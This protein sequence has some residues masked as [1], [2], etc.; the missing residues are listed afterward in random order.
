MFI[1]FIF[2]ISI[3]LLLHKDKYNFNFSL[4]EKL[5]VLVI[6]VFSAFRYGIGWD[7]FTYLAVIQGNL[8]T[9]I[10]FNNEF[11]NRFI[12]DLARLSDLPQLYFIFNSAVT[13]LLVSVTIK[14]NSLHFGLSL[15]LFIFFPFF[16]LNSFSVVRNFT[17]IA[18]VFYASKYIFN[19]NFI[20]YLLFIFIAASIHESSWI[21]LILYFLY[22]TKIKTNYFL[23]MIPIL[24][25]VRFFGV[26]IIINYLP[27]YAF[28]VFNDQV[29]QGRF[30]L[31]FYLFIAIITIFMSKKLKN[32]DIQSIFYINSFI[33][34]VI[35]FITFIGFGAISTRLSIFFTIN[36]V[37]LIPIFYKSLIDFRNRILFKSL[38]IVILMLFFYYTLVI[39]SETYLPYEFNF[40]IY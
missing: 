6:L 18:I 31:M 15:I 35:I 29:I 20:L 34:G 30:A 28:Y 7:Y 24:Y 4:N 40:F 21:A 25:F 17:A 38:Y 13:I 19:R 9:S 39:G 10:N 22:N 26:W 12:M 8:V 16:Y 23:F 14:K 5:A 33:L 36:I 37:F 11:G 32:L 3:A 2:G 1:Y 27:Q